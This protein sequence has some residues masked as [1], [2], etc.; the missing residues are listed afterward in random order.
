MTDFA[1]SRTRRILIIDDDALTIS[2]LE[3]YFTEQ[4]LQTG[5]AKTGADGLNDALANPPSLILLAVNLPDIPGLEVFRKL[6]S[7]ARSSHIPVMF[8]A[9]HMEARHQKELL[10]AGADDFITKPFDLDIL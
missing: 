4:K 3:P 6:R 2:A 8:L 1:T 5:S 9:G 7:R 10:S